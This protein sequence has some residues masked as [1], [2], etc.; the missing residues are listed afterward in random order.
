MNDTLQ[1]FAGCLT[2]ITF[3]AWGYKTF[4]PKAEYIPPAP[5]IT[6]FLPG[7][8]YRMTSNETIQ[9]EMHFSQPMDCD[10]ISNTIQINSTTANGDAPQ[11][12]MSSVQ[13][14]NVSAV[15]PSEWSGG[16]DT[17]FTFAANLVNVLDG[18]H[19]ISINNI[20][21]ANGTASTGVSRSDSFKNLAF[22]LTLTPELR[23]FLAT[24][25]SGR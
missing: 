22:S 5:V 8:D 13:C 23:P 18:I 14:T 4:V 17:A 3:G 6:K 25:W 11:I 2:N 15:E 24:Y 21:T 16:V 9:F 12:D 19:L 1:P 10:Q 20:S 7:H